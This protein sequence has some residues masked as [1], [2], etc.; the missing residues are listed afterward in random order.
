MEGFILIYTHGLI[1]TKYTLAL[2]L[3]V[4]IIIL[5]TINTAL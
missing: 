5:I 4:I 3:H 1:N 2:D